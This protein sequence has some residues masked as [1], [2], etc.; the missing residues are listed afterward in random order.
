MTTEQAQRSIIAAA[1]FPTKRSAALP[2]AYEQLLT[3]HYIDG[4]LTFVQSIALLE[5]HYYPCVPTITS[6][7]W[8]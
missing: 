1:L 5:A 8:T 6:A 3:T 2:S 7:T 4:T